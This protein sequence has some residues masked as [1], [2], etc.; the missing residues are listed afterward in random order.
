MQRCV[1]DKTSTATSEMEHHD[2]ELRTAGCCQPGKLDSAE[3]FPD[4][5]VLP[6]DGEVHP[7]NRPRSSTARSH[8][9][10]GCREQAVVSR[11]RPCLCHPNIP[12][13]FYIFDQ[14]CCKLYSSS[15]LIFFSELAH[16]CIFFLS[17]IL[18]FMAGATKL[19][20]PKLS[21]VNHVRRRSSPPNHSRK[22]PLVHSHHHH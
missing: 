13:V 7:C 11:R 15:E 14:G 5:P 10:A 20:L 12:T 21:R 8:A 3:R 6:R 16:G 19:T 9:L 1:K 22:S 18:I 2:N 17:L 4:A